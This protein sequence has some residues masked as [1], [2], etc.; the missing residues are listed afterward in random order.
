MKKASE[1]RGHKNSDFAIVENIVFMLIHSPLF[2]STYLIL[3]SFL[4]GVFCFL[5][6][7]IHLLDQN[8]DKIN[9]SNLY[10]NLNGKV[11]YIPQ[12]KIPTTFTDFISLHYLTFF[13]FNFTYTH[14]EHC[15]RAD[16][17]SPFFLSS[18]LT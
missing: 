7:A 10:S 9:C 1:S 3:I 13:F 14:H 12:S 8:V 17:L 2:I 4:L 18:H 11:E 15:F 16:A 6:F 5:F